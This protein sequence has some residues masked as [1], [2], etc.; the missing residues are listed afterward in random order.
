MTGLSRTY[1]SAPRRIA[2][3]AAAG[4]LMLAG[5]G[6]QQD[7]EPVPT[8][9][10]QAEATAVADIAGEGS[11]PDQ[12]SGTA[13]RSIADD[14]ARFTTYFDAGGRYRDLRNGDPWREGG[15]VFNDVQDKE[16]CFTPDGEN[17][18]RACW[19]PG[20][21]DGDNLYAIDVTGRRI[22]LRR[23][24]YVPPETPA[25]EESDDAGEEPA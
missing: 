14:G 13:W 15:W 11:T 24:E 16:L 21:M 23:V 19:Q 25:D 12:V 5:C 3:V 20:A 9:S 18:Q 10:P 8:A 2:L 22:E 1:P 4:G 17:A 7:S 6:T